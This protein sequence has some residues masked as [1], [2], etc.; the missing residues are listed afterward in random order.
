MMPDGTFDPAERRREKQAARDA[1]DHAL[2]RGETTREALGRANA[3]FGA[4]LGRPD[5]TRA[6]L[7]HS[8]AARPRAPEGGGDDVLLLLLGGGVLCAVLDYRPAAALVA[9]GLVLLYVA[10]GLLGDDA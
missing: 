5:F 4:V 9:L 3:P 6:G 1:D 10:F 7:P 2:E 8:R